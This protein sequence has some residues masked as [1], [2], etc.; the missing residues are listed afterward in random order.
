MRTLPEVDYQVLT[1]L[2]K[3]ESPVPVLE[4]AA[5]LGVDQSKVTAACLAFAGEGLCEVSERSD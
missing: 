5:E 4:L 1:A 2:A 3:R